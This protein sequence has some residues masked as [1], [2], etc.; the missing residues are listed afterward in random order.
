MGTKLGSRFQLVE[1]ETP[2]GYREVHYKDRP[3]NLSEMLDRTASRWP[4]QTAFIDGENRITYSQFL[5]RVNR[6]STG[7]QKEW[8]IRK[9]DRVA[10]LLGISLP[11][12]LAYFGA[13]P[14]WF[15]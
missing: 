2:E 15:P 12:C 4:N 14:L 7:L 3:T 6:I 10:L 1:E 11:F 5:D 8:G 13:G 9:G